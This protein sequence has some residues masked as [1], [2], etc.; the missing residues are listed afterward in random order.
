MLTV[1]YSGIAKKGRKQTVIPEVCTGMLITHRTTMDERKFTSSILWGAELNE[2]SKA[3]GIY[4]RGL[5]VR[6]HV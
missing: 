5:N 6:D 3:I 1:I 4:D 2:I